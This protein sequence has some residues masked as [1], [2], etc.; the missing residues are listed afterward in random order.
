MSGSQVRLKCL[1]L[2]WNMW[3]DINFK[4]ARI[5]LPSGG[6]RDDGGITSHGWLRSSNSK[7][8]SYCSTLVLPW[9]KNEGGP[10]FFS[11]SVE[12]KNEGSF[13]CLEIQP[14]SWLLFFDGNVWVSVSLCFSGLFWFLPVLWFCIGRLCTSRSLSIPRLLMSVSCN[15]CVSMPPAVTCLLVQFCFSVFPFS[16]WPC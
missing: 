14:W 1:V 8:F 3:V 7:V 13:E 11:V 10:I 15:P 6:K 12:C 16:S 9:C 5:Q 2:L 4:P